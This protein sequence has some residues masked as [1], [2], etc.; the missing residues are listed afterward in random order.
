MLQGSEPGLA[1]ENPEVS[2]VRL[3]RES[4]PQASFPQVDTQPTG[5]S[6]FSR[7]NRPIRPS[8]A[9]ARDILRLVQHPSLVELEFVQRATGSAGEP[10]FPSQDTHSTAAPAQ[11]RSDPVARSNTEDVS[12]RAPARNRCSTTLPDTGSVCA[13]FSG[14]QC[15]TG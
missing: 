8:A 2:R 7:P 13:E 14:G 10:G 12:P 3:R 5:T 11:Q 15:R 6:G 9:R 4:E 1:L